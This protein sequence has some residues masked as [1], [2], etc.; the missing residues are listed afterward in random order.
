[1]PKLHT[2]PNI[3]IINKAKKLFNF[4]NWEID[5]KGSFGRFC[6]ALSILSIE[7][8]D[9]ILDISRSFL[10][11]DPGKYHLYIKSAIA[12]IDD[13]RIDPFA[14]IFV[15]A[16]NVVEQEIELRKPIDERKKIGR[17][18]D[19]IAYYFNDSDLQDLPKLRNKRIIVAYSLN[20]LPKNFNNRKSLLLLV[21][22]FIGSGE[23]ASG[24]INFLIN[25]AKYDVSKISL[26]ALVSQKEGVERIK[27][28][29]VEV[30]CSEIRNKGITDNY[31]SPTK[32][33]FINLMKNIEDIINIDDKY[34]FGYSQSEALVKMI[35]TPN[36][37]FPV[38][39]RK[40]RTEDGQEF[41]P[42]FP[43]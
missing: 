41:T 3:E 37:T 23:T 8:Q 2:I 29:G 33:E 16:L 38:Y 36:N 10:K 7:Q 30:Y 39:W 22:D 6:G 28:K 5:N 14:K 35:R 13:E 15:L 21:D 27:D 9:C 1:M 32:D 31:S 25:E 17:S 43:R 26:L 11:V 24:C 19:V 20:G 34:R 40:S 18:S 12:G 42:P 4:H